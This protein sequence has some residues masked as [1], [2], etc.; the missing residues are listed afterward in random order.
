[1][2]ET[3]TNPLI[4]PFY[5]LIWAVFPVLSIALA[6]VAL[7]S[8]SRTAHRSRTEVVAWVA[9]VVVAPVVGSVAWLLVRASL[10][11]G[12]MTTAQSTTADTTKAAPRGT[13]SHP[14]S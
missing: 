14:V 1:V 13:A 11:R 9:F 8:I 5:D 2:P 4:P 10:R 3:T 6:I 12:Q 7:V